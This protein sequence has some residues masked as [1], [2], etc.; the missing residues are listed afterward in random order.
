MLVELG[1]G[2]LF[3]SSL[4]LPKIHIWNL[5]SVYFRWFWYW[6]LYLEIGIFGFM[7]WENPGL[8][9][10]LGL[11]GLSVEICCC[12]C[13]FVWFLFVG[14]WVG[15]FVRVGFICVVKSYEYGKLVINIIILIIGSVEL[16]NGLPIFNRVWLFFDEPRLYVRLT[17]GFELLKNCSNWFSISKICRDVIKIGG[18]IWEFGGFG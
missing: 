5:I 7:L 17:R 2:F 16:K 9:Y 12:V 11:C 8:L 18:R 15:C 6:R 1:R 4:D 10:L 3:R 14:R 13:L